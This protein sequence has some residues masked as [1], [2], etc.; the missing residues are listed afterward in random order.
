MAPAATGWALRDDALAPAYRRSGAWS[1]RTIAQDAWELAAARPEQIVAIAGD[2][3]VSVGTVVADAEALAVSLTRLGLKPGDTISYILPNWLEAL[4]INLAAARLGLVINPIVP[5]Y[6]A[7][8]LR[9]MLRDCRTKALFIT[10]RVRSLPIAEIVSGLRAELPE[11]RHVVHV[12]T[13][14]ALQLKDLIAQGRDGTAP[15][16]AVS[17]EAVK[18]VMYTSGTTGPA[19]GVLHSHDSTARVMA[20]GV[21]N[22]GLPAP[23]TLLIATPIGHIT[24]Y[25]WGLEAPFRIGARVVLLDRWDPAEAVRLIDRHAVEVTTGAAPFL[26]DTVDAAIA[27]GSRLPSLK[28]FGCGGAAVSPRLVRDAQTTF[29]QA[30]AFRIYGSTEAPNITQGYADPAA[31]DLAAETDGRPVDYEVRIIDGAGRDV[32]RGGEGEIIARGP[33]LCRGYTDPAAN[34]ATFDADGFC[35]TGDLGRITPEGAL[36]ITGRLKDLI[37]RGGENLSPKEIE[38]ALASHPLIREAA[39]VGKPHPRLGEVVCA[40]IVPAGDHLPTLSDLAAHLD[41]AGL[42]RQ[43]VPEDMLIVADMPR[44]ASGKI[45]KDELRRLLA[46]RGDQP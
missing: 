28:R 3:H 15:A 45:R 21:A 43:K 27:A 18:L 23:P 44:T 33:A 39:V 36:V 37:I 34:A 11:L 20:M 38:D 24:G 32:P 14:G 5:I 46:E 2:E 29:A 9:H 12:R 41:R 16:A 10:E 1:G 13:D 35:H 22:W 40:C 19:K 31:L 25:L 26:R 6:R 8:E 42:A 4:P 7:A 30:T 17:S